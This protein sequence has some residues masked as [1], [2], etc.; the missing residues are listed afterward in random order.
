MNGQPPT[1]GDLLAAHEGQCLLSAHQ[2][3]VKGALESEAA[4][5]LIAGPGGEPFGGVLDI[6]GDDG[7]ADLLAAHG[8]KV[9]STT[10]ATRAV[11]LAH[12][13]TR[14]GHGAIALVPNDHLCA[15]TPAI[16]RM[17]RAA[18]ERK[19]A[20]GLI[21]EDDPAG[22]PVP[23]PRETVRR[24][25]LPSIE[26]ADV[27]GLRDSIE[28]VMRLSRA[29]R[30]PV[31]VIVHTSILRAAQTLEARP[32]RMTNA[33][34]LALSRRRRR[35]RPGWAET[36]GFLRMVRRLELNSVRNMPS[37]GERVPVGF[38]TIGPADGALRHLTQ[39]LRL[40]GRVP[41]LHLGVVEPLDAPAV[42]RILER[43]ADVVVL[44]P[45]PG[46]MEA[47]VLAVAEQLRR[48]GRRPASVFGRR[49]PPGEGREERILSVNQCLHPSV[50][51]RTIVHLLHSIRPTVQVAAQLAPDPV[52]LPGETTLRGEDVGAP[53]AVELMR[54][55]LADVDQWLR[56]R[57]PLEE[58]D[59]EPT[60]LAVE[61]LEEA[62]GDARRLV[63]V[64]ICGA[65]Q[66][67]R[68]GTA[69]L[70]Q[71]A[72]D[73]RPWIFVVCD[74][75]GADDQDLERL[76]R[77]VIPANR[78]D[79]AR[80]VE[81]NMSDRIALRNVFREAALLDRLTIVLA[82]D[83]PPAQFDIAVLEKK[84]SEVD[85]LGFEP[86]QRVTWRLDVACAI[87]P[88]LDDVHGDR[89]QADMR[90]EFSIDHLP[91]RLK[92]QFRVR[93]RPLYEQVQVLRSQPPAR[94]WEP[95]GAVRLSM[96]SPVHAKQAQWR[97]HLA[98]YRGPGPGVA[99]TIL[100]IA[101]RYMGYV[102]KTVHEP[103]PLS[104]GRRAWAQLLFTRSRDTAA[105]VPAI[106]VVPYGEADLLLGLDAEETARSLGPDPALRIAQPGRTGAVIN[107]S[108]RA[109][110][111]EDDGALP[112]QRL[113]AEASDQL[114][115][116]HQRKEADYAGACRAWFDTDR[117][118]DVAMLGA[119]YQSGLIPVSLEAI[120]AAVSSAERMG[121]GRTLEV[122]RFGRRLAV[123][124]RFFNRSRE[125]RKESVSRILRRQELTGN[126]H[127]RSGR[128]RAERLSRLIRDTLTRMPGLTETDRG[129]Q[130]R[131]DAVIAMQRCQVWGGYAMAR[132]YSEMI[133]GLYETDR[134]DR[135]RSITRDAILPLADAMLIQDPIYIGTMAAGRE[136]RRY[137]RQR[138]N[139]KR[140]R[141]DQLERR[142]LTRVEFI[143]FRR[144]FRADI[145]TSDWPTRLAALARFIVPQAIRGTLRDR[146]VRKLVV[147][148]VSRAR[149]GMS[150]D[151][152]RFANAMHRLHEQASTGRLRGMASAELIML[153]GAAVQKSRED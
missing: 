138:L 61:G 122:F 71:A 33:V 98:G 20:A 45:R 150:R 8:A 123:D 38:I 102:V 119:A 39:V 94:A 62:A 30:G 44:E 16:R 6:A 95:V 48:A 58:E 37:P 85:R 142:F 49:I 11:T 152:D 141:N 101:G 60:A 153:L 12:H 135:G 43:C 92:R 125:G 59:I 82:R 133:I 5:T 55:T 132:R 23:C 78:A 53:A 4:V 31:G 77:A 28:Q 42:E 114:L 2:A 29:G 115:D 87:R 93:I 67:Q 32:N 128:R 64:E 90:S 121:F 117:V 113:L 21:I 66:F 107:T 24:L 137:T 109:T 80:I 151:Y 27:A 41:V 134:G 91:K 75:D 105:D 50:L 17:M 25:D 79:R 34:D 140:A 96:P 143:G 47:A 130:A 9:T 68:E 26:P 104:A 149:D 35:R 86:R 139:V 56:E 147:E 7:A 111:R 144:R 120:E 46:V 112:W 106:A 74:V 15:A 84:L 51:A 103:T 36:G 148:F 99:A 127:R 1:L 14:S 81:A 145:R 3:L 118:T 83:G 146:E 126:W 73:D 110:D 72:R 18:F 13:A 131:R 116:P 22:S 129:R 40:Y 97:V 57:A 136:Q 76:A 65:R 70:R 69:A 19:G 63:Q 100:S 52:G 124:D 89:D 108:G 88:P 10:D 54:R